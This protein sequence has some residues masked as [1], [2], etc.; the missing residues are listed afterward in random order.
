MAF[1]IFGWPSAGFHF[2]ADEK[3]T[4]RERKKALPPSVVV[5]F[6]SDFQVEQLLAPRLGSVTFGWMTY[7]GFFCQAFLRF[8]FSGLQLGSF[9]WPFEICLLVATFQPVENLAVLIHVTF[10]RHDLLKLFK[11]AA[12]SPQ[13]ALQR[14]ALSGAPSEKEWTA[15]LQDRTFLEV[16]LVFSGAGNEKKKTPGQDWKWGLSRKEVEFRSWWCFFDRF[17]EYCLRSRCRVYIRYYITNI[18]GVSFFL[19]ILAARN[20]LKLWVGAV[21]ISSIFHGI[22]VDG[23]GKAHQLLQSEIHAPTF[24]FG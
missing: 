1:S 20:Q 16:F 18:E 9:D 23:D 21:Q 17:F 24:C 8:W 13:D 22:D 6:P 14:M 12:G 7:L 5:A 10:H 19:G 4:S 3:Q 2:L 11:T 15:A